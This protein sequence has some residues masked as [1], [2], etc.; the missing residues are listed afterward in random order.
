MLTYERSR[1]LRLLAKALPAE[2]M[3][4][5][6]DAPDM[7]GALHRG[8]RNSPEYIP[9]CLATIAKERQEELEA[10][11]AQT[12]ANACAVLALQ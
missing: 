12:T 1:H 5:E 6:S 3:V 4:L 11:A 10:V 2:A 8:E 7:A 9:E